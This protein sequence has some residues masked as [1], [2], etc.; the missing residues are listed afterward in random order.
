MSDRYFVDTA[1]IQG[2]LDK[3]D[4]HHSWALKHLPTVLNA[5]GVWIT[6]AVFMEVG[7]ALSAVNRFAAATFMRQCYQTEN[8]TVV[9]VD[10]TLFE[11][12]L[13]LYENR[14]DKQWSLVDCVSFVVMADSNIEIAVTTDH[15]Y[16]QA[17]FKRLV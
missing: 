11:R 8:V 16:E 10:H 17:G 14:L 15:H 2:L 1:F 12:G 3:N 7:A 6:E 13:H 4:Q 5:S 9:S